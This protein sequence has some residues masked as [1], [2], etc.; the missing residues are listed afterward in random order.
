M[1]G[2][3]FVS[4]KPDKKVTPNGSNVLVV[5]GQ[6]YY[7]PFGQLRLR[8]SF[9]VPTVASAGEV[10]KALRPVSSH[11]GF[12]FLCEEIKWFEMVAVRVHRIS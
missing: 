11:F 7:I 8:A 6:K 2:E 1:A 5:L 4:V 10:A 3:W 12:E 9:V